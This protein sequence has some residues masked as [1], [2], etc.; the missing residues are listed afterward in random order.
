MTLHCP[1]C[2]HEVE[3]VP[4]QAM[5]DAAALT[6]Q[7]RIMVAAL[8]KAYPRHLGRD[9][10]FDQMYQFDPDGGPDNVGNSVAV[11]MCQI[12]KA[13]KPF[14]WTVSKTNGGKGARGRYRLE[15]IGD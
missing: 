7:Q 8:V 12:R 3:E 11:R 4:M 15:K 10:L 13:I 5:I 1:T 14:G 6:P 9:C 2:G